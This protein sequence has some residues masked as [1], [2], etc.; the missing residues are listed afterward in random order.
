MSSKQLVIG[1]PAGSLANPNR[2]G[3]LINLLDA[4]GFK[5]RGYENG[6]PTTFSTAN[7]LFGWDGRP[8]E[9]GSQMMLGELDIAIAGDDWIH[10]RVAEL[11][12][13]YSE[14]LELEKVLSLKRGGV[15][16]VGITNDS[17]PSDTVED[18]LSKLTSEKKLI[19]VVSEMPYLAVEWLQEKLKA[20]GKYEEFCSWSVQKYKTPPKNDTGIVV[21]ETWGKTE[22]K[23]KNG[24]ADIGI[25]I[26]QSGSALRNYGLKIIDEIMTSETGIWINPAIKDDPEKLDLLKMFLLNLHGTIN[27]E[28]RVMLLFNVPA[29]KKSSIEKYLSEYNL[30][31]E[32]PTINPGKS[33][34]QYSIQVE[35]NN[36]RIP[37]AKV[38]YELTKHGACSID[39]VPLLSSIPDLEIIQL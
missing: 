33:F 32:E 8:Q 16:I 20:I 22:A 30:Y 38:R 25:E 18:C 27:A 23:I 1:M 21:Y 10:E 34:A 13:E 26:T 2:G 5:T 12:I 28:N 35:T 29:E 7:F 6:G 37:L 17:N 39:T 15:R 19:N 4:A 24:G 36:P 3:N 9:F 14:K 31:A 11:K